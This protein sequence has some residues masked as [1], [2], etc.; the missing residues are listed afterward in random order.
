MSAAVPHI[1]TR[2]VNCL[3]SLFSIISCLHCFLSSGISPLC[4]FGAE[5]WQVGAVRGERFLFADLHVPC[6]CFCRVGVCAFCLREPFSM[7]A[8]SFQPRVL[9]H[10]AVRALSWPHCDRPTAPAPPWRAPRPFRCGETI[11]RS[12]VAAEL[13]SLLPPA[14]RHGFCFPGVENWAYFYL[15]DC[16]SITVF[17]GSPQR[18]PIFTSF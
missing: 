5:P 10:A 6:L 4:L 9:T 16:V 2:R 1:T 18:K 11:F 17:L 15:G 12:V 3:L 8:V 13:G 7:S 14:T